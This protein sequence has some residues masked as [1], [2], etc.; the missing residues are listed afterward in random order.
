MLTA[1]YFISKAWY[2][3]VTEMLDAQGAQLAESFF[4]NV[5]RIFSADELMLFRFRENLRPDILEHRTDNINRHITIRDYR[6]GFYLLDPFYLNLDRVRELG[7]LSLRDVIEDISFEDSEYYRHHYGITDLVDEFCY[8]LP[9]GH[10]GTILL[11]LARSVKIGRYRYSEI[12]IAKSIAPILLRFLAGSWKSLV[13]HTAFA[14]PSPH[15]A[16]LHERL[17]NARNNFGRSC[18]TSREFEVVQLMLRGYPISSIAKKLNMADG[19]TKV[20]RRSIYH[21]LDIGS[22]AELFSLFIDVVSAVK[23]VSDDDPLISYGN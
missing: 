8:C 4:T 11:S 12:D 22:H 7:A 6:N 3:C 1:D 18:L 14:S 5:C 17:E 15:E 9:D 21:K 10:G 13:S 19:T 23:V 20:H 16:T 2:T